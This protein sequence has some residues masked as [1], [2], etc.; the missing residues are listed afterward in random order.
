MLFRIIG[1]FAPVVNSELM[2]SGF[3]LVKQW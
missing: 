3:W 2:D 1:S